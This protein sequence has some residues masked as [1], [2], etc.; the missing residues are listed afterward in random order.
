[1]TKEN[2][3][4]INSLNAIVAQIAASNQNARTQSPPAP[5]AVPANTLAPTTPEL[6]D[7]Q[8]LG[9]AI[10][11]EIAA[12]LR[13]DPSPASNDAARSV[14]ASAEANKDLL[15]LLGMRENLDHAQNVDVGAKMIAD[16]EAKL[17]AQ[18]INVEA[19]ARKYASTWQHPN[20]LSAAEKICVYEGGLNLLK[21]AGCRT[22]SAQLKLVDNLHEAR[23]KATHTHRP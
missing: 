13:G 20:P 10:A 18:D 23:Y 19:S 21:K 3:Q 6:A 12:A 8:A 11:I 9:K 15:R 17:T 22:M 1:V 7:I 4:L 14:E 16:L 2:Q 5:P